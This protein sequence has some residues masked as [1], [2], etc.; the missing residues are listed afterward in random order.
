[1][2]T[3]MADGGHLGIFGKFKIAQFSVPYFY[4]AS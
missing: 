1:M 4:I 2:S 3:F